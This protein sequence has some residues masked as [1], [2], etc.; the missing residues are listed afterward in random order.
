MGDDDVFADRGPRD[1]Y[2]CGA[3]WGGVCGWGAL[4]WVTC[5]KNGLMEW[6][7]RVGDGPVAANHVCV[8]GESTHRQMVPLP[9]LWGSSG[10]LCHLG[11][12]AYGP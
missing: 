10:A 2:H 5:H 12:V 7:H 11:C 8:Q 3:I 4:F 1:G 6:L 9:W